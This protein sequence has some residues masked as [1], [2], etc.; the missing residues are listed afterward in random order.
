MLRLQEDGDWEEEAL[1]AKITQSD[2]FHFMVPNP[3]P[4]GQSDY[5]IFDSCNEY[6]A[7]E[8]GEECYGRKPQ[9]N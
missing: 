9:I 1:H 2:R 7:Q 3:D 4:E 5:R 8:V 6:E